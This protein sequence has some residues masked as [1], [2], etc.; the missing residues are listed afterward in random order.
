MFTST[1]VLGT[2][3]LGLGVGLMA[4]AR[5]PTKEELQTHHKDLLRVARV[6]QAMAELA[7]FREHVYVSKNNEKKADA[8]RK[9]SAEFKTV[10]RAFRDAVE[11]KEPAETRK[12]AVR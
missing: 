12:A 8:W 2:L 11:S 5:P 1:R 9:V 7:P 3:A 10:T 4:G 6:L